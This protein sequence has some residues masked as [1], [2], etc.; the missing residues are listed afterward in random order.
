MATS[1]LVASTLGMAMRAPTLPR[2][3]IPLMMAGAPIPV[4]ET[5]VTTDTGLKYLDEKVGSG[6]T[7]DNGAVVEVAYTG[8]IETTGKEFDS[9]VG[10]A[11]IAFAVGTGKVIPGWDQGIATMKVGGKRRLS[12]PA[13]LAYGERGAGD[14]IPP[15]SQL[16]FECELVGIKAGFDGFLASF[17]GGLPNV[18]LVTLLALSFIPYF[19]PE[20]PA[21]W[22]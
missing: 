1:L 20:K 6:E 22:Q 5:W 15:N 21:F 12:I 19:L 13:E 10:R 18:I 2:S 7:P 14:S 16:Q 17:P 9:S 8:W 4:D 3:R 11:P